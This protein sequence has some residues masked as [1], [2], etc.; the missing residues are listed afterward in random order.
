MVMNMGR[1][2]EQG[3]VELVY[4]PVVGDYAAALRERRSFNRAGRLQKVALVLI[5]LAW[6][7]DLGLAVG[8]GDANMFLLIWMPL[9][10]A[11]L[12][13]QPWLTARQVLK[14]AARNGV[15]RATVSEAGLTVVTE[16]SSTSVG[17]AAQPRYRETK[18]L[19]V[20]YSDD[21]N[22]TCFTVLPKRGVAHPAEVDRLREI[23]GR[24]LTR[25]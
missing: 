6:A 8:G 9:M 20:L 24:N 16:H 19:F 10:V 21:K 23:L 3:V 17:F 18:E 1:D 12:W 13:F 4:Q 2:A 7:L 22:A 15:F 11:L 25:V 14:A 5:A